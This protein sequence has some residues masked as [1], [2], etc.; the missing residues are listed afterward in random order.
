VYYSEGV[1]VGYRWFDAMHQQPLFP[2][3]YGLSYT[4]FAF[5]GLHVSRSGTGYTVTARVTN[6]GS[7]S[8]AE[9]A[10]LYVGSPASANE[11]VRQ[12]KGYAKVSLKAGQS[13]VVRMNLPRSALA[14]WNSAET[15]WTVAGGTYRLYVGDSSR[16]LPLQAA[17]S[18]S[19]K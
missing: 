13:S 8:G 6:T 17:I 1:Y 16:H 2:F 14:A 9:V 3:G 10:Q 11:P 4:S 19:G 7:R 15:G 12:L 18:V 5:S